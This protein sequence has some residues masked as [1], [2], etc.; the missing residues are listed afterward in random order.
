M[1]NLI[2]IIILLLLT[3]CATKPA[4]P[5]PDFKL[6][7]IGD[8]LCAPTEV[9]RVKFDKWLDDMDKYLAETGALK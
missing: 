8:M 5:W 3:S 9:D 2:L 4:V 7:E 1:K 6:I